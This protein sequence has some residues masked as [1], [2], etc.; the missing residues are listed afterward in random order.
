MNMQGAQNTLCW[1]DFTVALIM[2]NVIDKK[3]IYDNVIPGKDICVYID[4][5]DEF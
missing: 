1:K 3:Q 5:S 2:I 4:V